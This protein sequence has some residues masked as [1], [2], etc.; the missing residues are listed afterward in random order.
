M[1]FAGDVAA[2]SNSSEI[3]D[4]LR[5]LCRLTGMGFC[6]VARVTDE[7]WIACQV[8][9]QVEFGLKPGDELQLK[10]TICDEIRESREAV[11]IDCVADAPIWATH[12]TPILY[13]FQSYVSV[14]LIR[15]DASFFGT[16]CAVDPHPHVVDTPEMRQAIQRLAERVTAFLDK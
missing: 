12:P 10:T 6:A 16:L 8:L 2:L 11:Y 5:E 13:G 7:R 15:S 3:D 9:D 14:P 1:D 4:I